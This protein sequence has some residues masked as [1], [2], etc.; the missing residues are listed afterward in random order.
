MKSHMGCQNQLG[1][2]LLLRIMF[3]RIFVV[4]EHGMQIV[5]V[6]CKMLQNVA[7]FRKILQNAAAYCQMMKIMRN[8]VKYRK[9]L[10]LLSIAAT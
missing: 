1:Y 5:L 8:I 7:K 3:N 10:Q 6:F 2:Y 4:D 9:R